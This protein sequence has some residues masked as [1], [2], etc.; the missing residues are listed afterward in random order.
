MP[1]KK[2]FSRFLTTGTRLVIL[3]AMSMAAFISSAMPVA[4]ASPTFDLYAVSGTMLLPGQPSPVNVNVWGYNSTGVAATQPGGPQLIVNQGDTVTITL[5]NQLSEATAL[6]FPGQDNLIPDTTPVAPTGTRSYTFTANRPGTYLYE[7]GLLPNAQHQVAMGLY[8]ALIVLPTSAPD[9]VIPG[10]AYAD[11]STAYNDEGVLVLSEI[12]P[13]LN[14]RLGGPAGFDM[15]KYA[16]RYFLINGKVYPNTDLIPTAAGNRVLLRYLNAGMQFHSMTLMG[17]HQT[18]IA[19]DGSPLGFTHRMVAETFGP[20]QTVDTIVTVPSTAVGGSKFALYDGNLMMRNSNASGFGGMMTFL[21]VAGVSGGTGAPITS[22]VALSPNPSNGSAPVTLSATLTSVV[23]ATAAEYFVDVVGADGTGCTITGSP[24]SISVSIPASGGVAPCTDLASLASGN[25]T[26][27]VHGTN[28]TWGPVVSSVL[29]LDKA[30]PVS[31][32]LTLTPNRTNGTVNVALTATGNDSTTGNGNITA[33]EYFI[34]TVGAPGTGSAMSLNFV[35]PVTSLSASIPAATVNSLP[36]GTHTVSV[37]SQDAFGNWGPLGTVNLIVDKTGP[38]AN[39]VTAAPNPTN[40]TLG[41]NASTPAVRVT[42]TLTDPTSG[43]IQSNIS[44]AE[45]FLCTTPA[46]GCAVGANGTGFVFAA[47]DGT[48]NNSTEISHSD[49][50]LATILQLSDG[51]HT[52]YVHGKDVAG[53]WGATTAITL[54]VDKAAPT[55]SSITLTPSSFYLGSTPT[56]LLTVNGASDNTGGTGIAGGEYWFGTTDP[57]PGAGTAFSGLSA[58][59]PVSSLTIGTYTVRARLRDALG[60]WSVAPN[61]IRSATLTVTN[62]PLYFSTSGNT[63][64]PGVGGT[65]DDADIYFFNGSTFSRSIDVTSITNPL[66]TGAN[67]DGFDRVDATHF[68]MSF[69][70]TVTISLPG[71]DLTVQDEDIVFYDAGTWSVY[72]DGTPAATRGLSGSDLDAISIVGSTLYFSTDDNDV[73]VGVAGAG[74]DADIYSWNGTSFSRVVDA[75]AVGWSTN[76][77]DGLVW[78]DATHVYL[79]YS[80]DTTVPV[81]GAVQDEDIVYNNGSTWSVY[82]DGTASGLTSGNLDI[83]AFDLP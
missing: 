21:S 38:A 78:V 7:A 23:A 52:I 65:S 70:G 61:G 36:E 17:M 19:N 58:N 63:N 12:D 22:N 71:P 14:N 59:I 26:F 56:V 27:Y 57:A 2:L 37:R 44:A 11:A 68:Y 1:T 8:G 6:L 18:V 60:N 41:V 77:V 81:I 16:P 43:T 80:A 24:T 25:H 48:F 74:D 73:P 15:R 35:A 50:P 40:G 55:F 29:N 51:N 34:D 64:P 32:G 66:P 67:V 20:G 3:A 33:A 82:F 47:D 4:A 30:G 9:V 83:D 39:S 42:A 46:I 69:N 76:N 62:P 5:H 45:G 75:S 72:F 79:S 10:Q 49:I 31:T 28:G 53:N 54:L 13:A